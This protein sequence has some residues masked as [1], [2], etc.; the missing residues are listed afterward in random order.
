MPETI[1]NADLKPGTIVHGE[2][3]DDQYM[4]VRATRTRVVAIDTATLDVFKWAHHGDG[5][6]VEWNRTGSE[7]FTG[8]MITQPITVHPLPV[9]VVDGPRI[10]W[11]RD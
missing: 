6:R 7:P 10:E 1:R 8:S 11:F 5:W 4:I 3:D 9:G 2:T